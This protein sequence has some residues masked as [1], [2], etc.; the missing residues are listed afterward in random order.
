MFK[1]PSCHILALILFLSLFFLPGGRAAAD[2]G[3]KP[4]LDFQFTLPAGLTIV[5]G[6]LLVCQDEACT[7]TEPLPE[8]GPQG[9][10]C[11][12]TA[13][14]AILYSVSSPFRLQVTFSDG[15]TRLS[16]IFE[17]QSSQ[18]VYTVEVG[19]ADLLVERQASATPLIALLLAVLCIG[20]LLLA[21]GLVVVRLLA[22]RKPA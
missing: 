7:E 16:N 2:I 3:P 9:F 10:N 12:P 4:E 15:V 5:S 8:L 13:C 11:Q 1:K 6:E 20:L 14:H 18:N 21:G 19:E 22:K 17:A